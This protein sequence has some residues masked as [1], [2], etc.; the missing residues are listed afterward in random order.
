M[1]QRKKKRNK[2]LP[3]ILILAV[4]LI[5]VLIVGKKKGWFGADFQV[6]VLTQKVESRTITELITANGKIQPKTE[7]KISPDVS[8]EIIDLKVQE[9]E[10][11]KTGQLLVIIKPDIYIQ[12][13]NRA[14]AGLNSAKAML[15]QAQARML[16]SELA[17][18]RSKQLY[19]QQTI[20]QSEFESADAAYKIAQ[21]EVTSAEFSVKS[22]E[23][24]VAEAQEQLVKTK[25]YAP[26]DGTVSQLNVEKGERVVG[27]NMY[28]GTVMMIIS[29]LEQMEVKVEVNENDIV[30]VSKNDTALVEVDAYL[31]RKFK[32]IVTEIANSA[33]TVGASGD[34]VT[35][36]DVKV[37]LLKS[38]YA[39]LIDSV[40]M[41]R[42][43][44]R[45]GMSATVD[46]Q[47]DTRPDVIAV[48]IQAVTTRI[49]AEKQEE[50][51]EK[52]VADKHEVVFVLRDGRAFSQPV[53]TG[54]QD[55]ANIEIESGIQAGDEI[56]TGPFNVVSRTLKDSMDVKRVDEKELFSAKK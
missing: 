1:Q 11:V 27:T 47:T 25:I 52:K 33:N 4:V 42:Y 36:F 49:P 7:V 6:N 37:L 46:V 13:L 15:A 5:I 34:Q 43:P 21:A 41:K 17:F 48:P 30:K 3:L 38:S 23:A 32:G 18:K 54:I 24:S 26:M 31:K 9:G 12:A 20:A 10:D 29:D 35:N 45:P 16:E 22:N 2:V 40:G 44:F 56:I 51:A 19:D 50:T 14:E 8:G 53:V 55:N 28:E 39:D